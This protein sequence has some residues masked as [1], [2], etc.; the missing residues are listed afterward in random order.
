MIDFIIVS[1]AATPELAAITQL[2]I[3]SLF[4]SDPRS[5]VDFHVTMVESTPGIRW[6]RSWLD[7]EDPNVGTIYTDGNFNYHR[8]LNEGYKARKTDADL[9]CFA[10]NDLRF[11]PTWWSHMVKAIAHLPHVGSF[12]P[13]C[14]LTQP[15]YGIHVNTGCHFGYRIRYEVSGWC[16]VM[17]KST[18]IAMGGFDERF[19]YWYTDNDYATTLESL[20]IKHCLVTD[21]VVQHHTESVGKTSKQ[22]F[23]PER[24]DGRTLHD[25]T[26]GAKAVYD[27]KWGV[28]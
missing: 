23:T 24:K 7:G 19:V 22:A 25:I 14:P 26:Y 1:N 16:L 18:Y 21:S 15:Q 13:I 12:S 8:F 2:C 3:D 20:G 27:A 9:L 17:R 28:T 10:N 11:H 5:E 4:S 6:K